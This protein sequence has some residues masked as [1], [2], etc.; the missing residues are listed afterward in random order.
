MDFTSDIPAFP[1]YHFVSASRS[2]G[3]SFLLPINLCFLISKM[4]RIIS[5]PFYNIILN[6]KNGYVGKNARENKGRYN[7]YT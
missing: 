5:Y 1:A 6:I 7:Y 4:E 3:F 2:Q